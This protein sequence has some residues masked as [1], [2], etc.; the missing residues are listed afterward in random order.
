MA[1]QFRQLFSNDEN[2]LAAL[3]EENNRA[4]ITEF[5][6]PFPMT[7][8]TAKELLNPLKKD[9][10]FACILDDKFIG[11]SMLRGFDEGFSVPCF[12]IFIDLFHQNKGYG[13]KLTEWTVNW[14]DAQKI[15]DIRLAVYA[16]N[17]VALNLYQT[18]GFKKTEEHQDTCGRLRFV[19]HRYLNN[20]L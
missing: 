1:L 6:H 14:A 16:A 7:R 17:K 2:Q 8:E 20:N 19:M 10:F 18:L 11:F 4:E 13:R 9:L 3:F 15:E 12:G 5:F